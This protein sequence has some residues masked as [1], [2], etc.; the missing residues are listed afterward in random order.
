MSPVFL[1]SAFLQISLNNESRQ[2]TAFLNDS[3]VYQYKISPCGINL[4]STF[5]SV[6]LRHHGQWAPGR[7]ISRKPVQQ[8]RECRHQL[9]WPTERTN[10]AGTARPASRATSWNKTTDQIP[11][12]KI[13]G[14]RHLQKCV[15]R[16]Q[17]WRRKRKGIT[18]GN[19]K[20]TSLRENLS[21]CPRHHLQVMRPYKEP[22]K[23]TA[24]CQRAT[25][26]RHEQN[27]SWPIL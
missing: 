1:S 26:S 8:H 5:V 21:C 27:G 2:Q 3:T 19:K 12:L 22:H 14:F 7:P 18:Q 10:C 4:S 9:T 23:I 15:W 6:L 25:Y 13:H 24:M 16:Q 17:N 11:R 20:L